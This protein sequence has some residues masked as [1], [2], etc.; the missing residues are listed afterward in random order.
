MIL[1]ALQGS[2]VLWEAVQAVQGFGVLVEPVKPLKAAKS[3]CMLMKPLQQTEFPDVVAD[4]RAA[5]AL[6]RMAT[7]GSYVIAVEGQRRKEH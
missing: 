4:P 3:P 1:R 6:E 2:T 7:P 5:H